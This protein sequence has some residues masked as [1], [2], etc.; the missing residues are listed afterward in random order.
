MLKRHVLRNLMLFL[1]VSALIACGGKEERKAKYMAEGKT[2]FKAGN[3]EKAKLAFKNVLQIDPKDT[4]SRF[5]MAESLS[6]LG[7]VQTAVGHYM[8]VINEDPKHLMSRVRMGQIFLVIKRT[9]EAEEKAGEAL[10]IAPADPEAIVL[11]AGVLA[12]QNKPDEA[13][14]K[15]QEALQKK[16]DDVSA[17]MLI[18]SLNARAGKIDQAIASL[19]NNIENNPDKT[20][21]RFM[22]VS[23]Y[24]QTKALDSELDLGQMRLDDFG[25]G[26]L[27]GADATRQLRRRQEAEIA[28]HGFVSGASIARRRRASRPV[29]GS[30]MTAMASRG[31]DSPTPRPFGS[32]GQY[33]ESGVDLSLIRANMRVTPT[34]RAR[35]AERARQAALRVQEIGRAARPK[36][37]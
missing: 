10:A 13:I 20:A 34:E 15:A 28:A 11:M 4:E 24:M 37:A 12:A 17:T 1:L 31:G 8:A 26:D 30:R 33:D 19:I 22:L 18:A 23:Y 25:D 16:P 14:A 21:P 6:K 3:Y 32:P 27:A 36:P 29:P 35:R 7:D 5:Q 2:L 9:K